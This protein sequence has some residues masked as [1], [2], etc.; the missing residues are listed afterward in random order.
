MWGSQCNYG[1]IWGN[2]SSCIC[3]SGS[4]CHLP[5]LQHRCPIFLLLPG[6]G[7][8]IVALW[9]STFHHPCFFLPEPCRSEPVAMCVFFSSVPAFVSAQLFVNPLLSNSYQH[10]PYHSLFYFPINFQSLKC[11]PSRS[12][13]LSLNKRVKLFLLSSFNLIFF[14]LRFFTLLEISGN[15]FEFQHHQQIRPILIS[16]MLN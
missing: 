13:F 12:L 6:F 3:D 15:D 14:S 7:V 9:F 8:A 11:C 1:F 5:R 10:V 2:V 16:H 4:S